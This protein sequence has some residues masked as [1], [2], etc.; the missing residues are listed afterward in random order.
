M[1]FNFFDSRDVPDSYCIVSGFEVPSIEESATSNGSQPL[2][3]VFISSN[4]ND[5]DPFPPAI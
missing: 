1:Q 2:V 3:L 4:V 5:R